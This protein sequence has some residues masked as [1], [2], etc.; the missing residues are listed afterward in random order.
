MVAGV[1]S[2]AGRFGACMVVGA[3]MGQGKSWGLSGSACSLSGGRFE[4]RR[5]F[6]RVNHLVEL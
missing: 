1:D 2:G 6:V 5:V 4:D 3:A